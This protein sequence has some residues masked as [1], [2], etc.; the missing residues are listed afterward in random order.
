M[1]PIV[2]GEAHERLHPN[3]LGRSRSAATFGA[4]VF[5]SLAQ[6]QPSA[7]GS[8]CASIQTS[9]LPSPAAASTLIGTSNLEIPRNV[10]KKLRI[11]PVSENWRIDLVLV[12]P[13]SLPKILRFSTNTHA[14]RN[15]VLLK[16]MAA[17]QCSCAHRFRRVHAVLSRRQPSRMQ[18]S[19][20]HSAVEA[21]VR[22]SDNASSG[23]LH[24]R[25]YFGGCGTSRDL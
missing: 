16:H 11:D 25:S 4:V 15:L 24:P 2:G 13:R 3:T 20:R 1:C 10:K 19:T 18:P 7:I 23:F 5:W 9:L 22:Q 6:R 12:G 21:S 17:T 8:L 14:H